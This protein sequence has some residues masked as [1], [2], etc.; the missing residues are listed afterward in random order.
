MDMK[1]NETII[2]I[3]DKKLISYEESQIINSS[4]KNIPSGL[5]KALLEDDRLYVNVLYFLKNDIN[6]LVIKSRNK[7]SRR[8]SI[9]IT[10]SKLEL[11]EALKK[12]ISE[13]E[14][15]L[16]LKYKKRYKKVANHLTMSSFWKLYKEEKYVKSLNRKMYLINITDIIDL[17]IISNEEYNETIRSKEY[18]NIPIDIFGYLFYSFF[19]E[20]NIMEKY[21]FPE[22]INKRIL[23]ILSYKDIDYE[24]LDELNYSNKDQLK[25][26]KIDEDLEK[27][28][29]DGMNPRYSEIEKAIFIY[30]KMCKIFS[31]SDEYY[32]SEQKGIHAKKH[33]DIKNI[34]NINLNNREVVC[35]EFNMIYAKLLADLN[36]NFELV[37]PSDIINYGSGHAYLKFK[38]GKYLVIADAVISIITSDMVSAKLNTPLMGL[39]SINSNIKTQ[40]RFK[41]LLNKIYLDIAKKEQVDSIEELSFD[42]ALEEY[43][44]TIDIESIDLKTRFRLMIEKISTSEFT[45]L[46]ALSYLCILKSVMFSEEE[47]ENNIDVKIVKK[48]PD[49]TGNTVKS[50]A[51]ITLNYKNIEENRE[52]NIYYIY[53]P[54]YGIYNTTE[55]ELKDL[56]RTKKIKEIYGQTLMKRKDKHAK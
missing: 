14:K 40:K 18:K 31:Y 42:K 51:V 17:L 29:L 12:L 1:E 49:D 37:G 10:F 20:N 33:R 16:S 45:K 54:E 56:L 47:K 44:S 21:I 41:L 23:N 7:N 46:E 32:V 53:D 38:S 39:K 52:D 15:E 50:I 24:Y 5:L 25:D 43:E 55:S 4:N 3:S 27:E 35:Y 48:N 28:I 11:F 30:I 19:K 26:I 36:I 34:D 9:V 6:K 13:Y 2:I 22:R 8:D